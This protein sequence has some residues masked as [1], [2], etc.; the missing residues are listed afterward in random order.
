MEE[1]R[2]NLIGEGDEGEWRMGETDRY[3]DLNMGVDSHRRG[4]GVCY[5]ENVLTNNLSIYLN[6][7]LF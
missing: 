6:V 4:E 7:L 2:R 3:L 1:R 5:D